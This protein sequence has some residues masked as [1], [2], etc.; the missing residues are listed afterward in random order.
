[1]NDIVLQTRNLNKFFHEPVEFHV[2]KDIN[3]SVHKGEFVSMIGKSGS[4]KSTLLYCLSTM[5]NDYSGE[6]H[7]LSENVTGRKDK[8]MAAIRNKNIWVC[9]PIPLSAAR[10]YLSEKRHVAGSETG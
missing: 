7:I 6:V 4:G 9:L 8:A 3:V 5:D 2:L 10:V 1:M